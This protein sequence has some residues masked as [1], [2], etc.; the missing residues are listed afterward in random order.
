MD[1]NIG[2]NVYCPYCDEEKTIMMHDTGGCMIIDCKKC[3]KPFLVQYRLVPDIS[4]AKVEF[5]GSN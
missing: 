2:T 5:V 3:L 1:V 4:I